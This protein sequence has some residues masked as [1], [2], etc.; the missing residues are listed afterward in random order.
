MSIY[1]ALKLNLLLTRLIA[2]NVIQNGLAD[3]SVT[4]VCF[5]S[6]AECYRFGYGRLAGWLAGLLAGWLTHVS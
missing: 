5:W 1:I 2:Q 6:L 3:V 4:L